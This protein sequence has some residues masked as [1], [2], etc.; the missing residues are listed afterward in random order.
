[1]PFASRGFF[2]PT[3][4]SRPSTII[5]LGGVLIAKGV[6]AGAVLALIIGAAGISLPE[7]ILLRSLFRSA[8]IAAFVAVV[9]TTAVS[10][11][12]ATLLLF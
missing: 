9:F 2:V 3:L 5:P 8:L 11:G 4:C 1:M 7:L 6:G 12:F 10:A